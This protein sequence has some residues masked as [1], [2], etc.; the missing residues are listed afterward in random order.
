MK[1]RLILLLLLCFESLLC[2]AQKHDYHWVLADSIG[3]DFNYSPPRIYK[4]NC[5]DKTPRERTLTCCI[6]DTN[7]YLLYYNDYIGYSEISDF[8]PLV[9]IRDKNQDFI[10]I[11]DNRSYFINHTGDSEGAIF[12]PSISRSKIYF[13]HNG[14]LPEHI[15]EFLPDIGHRYSNLYL[16]IL[17]IHKNEIITANEKISARQYAMGV[18]ASLCHDRENWWILLRQVE[19]DTFDLYL[20]ETK[21]GELNHIG[22]MNAGRVSSGLFNRY[23]SIKFSHNGNKIIFCGYNGFAQ[24]F[25]FDR[26]SGKI[27][28]GEY[29]GIDRYY[30]RPFEERY[31]YEDAY[32]SCEFSQD[33]S[34]LYLNTHY[35]LYQFDISAENIR[36]SKKMI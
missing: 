4:I 6:S 28:A 5:R 23:S 2:N 16:S 10:P 34:Y 14:V 24:L 20:L 7:G 9:S 25:N 11:P 13:L 35:T 8:Y 3:I 29:L 22:E 30:S 27:S 31:N 19:S 21:K 36:S 26:C 1:R 15:N 12:L 32:V 33:D 17:D 18:G